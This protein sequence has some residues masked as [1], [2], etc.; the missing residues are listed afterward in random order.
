VILGFTWAMLGGAFFYLLA[1]LSSRVLSG[2][3]RGA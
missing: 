1:A 2:Q 3:P